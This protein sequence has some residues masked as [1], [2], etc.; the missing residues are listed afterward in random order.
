MTGETGQWQ[1][2]GRLPWKTLGLPDLRDAFGE[3]LW[4][5]VSSKHKGLLNCTVSPSC[6]DMGPEAA[7]G[8]ITVRDAAGTVLHDG[9]SASP[10]D[11][12]K[13]GAAAV[14][15]AP[16]PPLARWSGL[17]APGAIQSRSCEGGNCNAAGRCL[18]SRRRSRRNATPQTTST[19]LPA[20][21]LR[22]GQRPLHGPQ[23]RRGAPRQP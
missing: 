15:I 9:T 2:L 21:I 3:R 7:I 6:L 11:P 4:Y 13:G 16:G 17:G 10:Y 18:T 1:R 14:I 12:G 8:T 22:R 19:A 20:G 5:A 23:R